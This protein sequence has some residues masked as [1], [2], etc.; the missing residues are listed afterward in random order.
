MSLPGTSPAIPRSTTTARWP[1]SR[2]PRAIPDRPRSSARRGSSS[3]RTA[4]AEFAILVR[5]DVK[6]RGLGRAL[7]EKLV[8]YGRSR[9]K[10]SLIG[11][12]DPG[13]DPM[14]ALARR[15]GMEVEVAP[16]A[17]LAV[18]HLDL[19]PPAPQGRPS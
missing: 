14:I 6:R 3:I 4:T 5:S 9:G 8:D 12:I 17:N 1:S 11:Q 13:N 7:I 15:C 19:R 18:A 16:D 2:L 10:S